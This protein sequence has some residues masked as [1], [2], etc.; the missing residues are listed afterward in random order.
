MARLLNSAYCTPHIHQQIQKATPI[1]HDK[2]LVWKKRLKLQFSENT[3]FEHAR[4][5][6]VVLLRVG[7]ISNAS[8]FGPPVSYVMLDYP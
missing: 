3:P 4:L 1:M 5:F 2:S 7:V 6:Y 8:H